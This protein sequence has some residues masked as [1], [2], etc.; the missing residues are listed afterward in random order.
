MGIT[1]RIGNWIQQ[2]VYSEQTP[3]T[4][5]DIA[6][7]A[8]EQVA[9]LPEQ[10]R[11]AEIVSGT[12]VPD[13][14]ITIAN[15]S[16]MAIAQAQ[17][18]TERL[19]KKV[20]AFDEDRQSPAE[21]AIVKLFTG[22][23]YVMPVI[24]AWVVG[25]AIGDAFSGAF[26]WKDNWSVYGHVISLFFEACLPMLGFAVTRAVKRAFKD[27]SQVPLC[28]ILGALFLALAIGNAFATMY[29]VEKHVDTA[30]KFAMV[31][32]YFRSFGPLIID[33]VSTV[34]LSVVIVKNLQKFLA[35]M[36][37][38]S[39]AV[40]TVAQAEIAVKSAFSKAAQDKQNAQFEMDEKRERSETIQKFY[41]I[42][43]QKLLQDAES[44]LLEGPDSGNKGKY[45]GGW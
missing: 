31:S 44:K 19:R 41:R 4:S 10:G 8:N 14:T 18:H 38:K 15:Q 24:T 25:M 12:W 43:N 29:L 42:Q 5:T 35:D 40:A 7:S 34:F 11:D 21:W 30:N 20:E 26:T 13:Q 33:V 36:Q 45:G 6:P 2:K 23:A 3:I 1:T 16:A 22:L 32:M 27:R 37:T 9:V 28:A 17:K 39:V